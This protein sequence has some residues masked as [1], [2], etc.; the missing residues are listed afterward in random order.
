M[1][2]QIL[3]YTELG[4]SPEVISLSELTETEKQEIIDGIT[5]WLDKPDSEGWWWFV[6]NYESP[7]WTE[8]IKSFIFIR[9]ATQNNNLYADNK[10]P[11][12]KY[13]FGKWSKAQVPEVKE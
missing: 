4:K 10:L 6:G 3:R 1:S 9:K 13:Y 2:L 7:D 11:Y 12:L 5:N 8:G